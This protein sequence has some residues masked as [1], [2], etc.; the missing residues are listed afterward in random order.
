MKFVFSWCMDN[1]R[2]LIYFGILNTNNNV[3]QNVLL[4]KNYQTVIYYVPIN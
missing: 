4:L 1:L 3:V 2:M